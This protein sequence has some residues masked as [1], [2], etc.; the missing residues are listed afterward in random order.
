MYTQSCFQKFPHDKAVKDIIAFWDSVNSTSAIQWLTMESEWMDYFSPL[1]CA[2]A[3]IFFLLW[4][5]YE[6]LCNGIPSVW[7][8]PKLKVYTTKLADCLNN[9][10]FDYNAIN[11]YQLIS[12]KT[13]KPVHDKTNK[14]MC[15]QQRLISLAIR[16]VWSV[17]I[18]GRAD[19]S[20]LSTWKSLESLS[21]LWAHIDDC[22]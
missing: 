22:D 20:S 1:S 19:Q 17:F 4:P 6:H 3:I 13:H 7:N 10:P 16:P 15:A 18:V 8:Y 11:F 12:M 21:I 2:H 5:K 14:M 9:F